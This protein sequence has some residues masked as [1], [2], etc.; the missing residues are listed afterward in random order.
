MGPRSVGPRSVGPGSVGP[1]SGGSGSVGPGSALRPQTPR[2]GKSPSELSGTPCSSALV[3]P[4]S[5]AWTGPDQPR[6]TQP[7]PVRPGL[8]QATPHRSLQDHHPCLSCHSVM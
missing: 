6:L 7:R 8:V 5:P 4:H 1:R 3:L 2:E